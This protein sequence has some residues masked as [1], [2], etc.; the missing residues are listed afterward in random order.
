MSSDFKIAEFAFGDLKKEEREKSSDEKNGTRMTFEPDD[1]VFHKYRYN[2][3]YVEQMQHYGNPKSYWDIPG[4]LT[5]HGAMLS[6]M[7]GPVFVFLPLALLALRF[8]E[9]RRLL[10]PAFVLALP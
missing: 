7:Y 6:G 4:D 9:G 1:S 10:L 8:R 5:L 3:E 2:K